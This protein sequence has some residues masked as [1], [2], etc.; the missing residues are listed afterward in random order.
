MFTGEGGSSGSS[1][2]GSLAIQLRA[3]RVGDAQ[4][5]TVTGELAVPVDPDAT[6]STGREFQGRGASASR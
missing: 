3:E 5:S 2:C 1:Q 4:M 6:A